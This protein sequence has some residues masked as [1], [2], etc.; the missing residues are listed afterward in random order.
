MGILLPQHPRG[1]KLWLEQ[2]VPHF[3]SSHNSAVSV[4]NHPPIREHNLATPPTLLSPHRSRDTHTH[5]NTTQNL[6]HTHT[7]SPCSCPSQARSASAQRNSFSNFPWLWKQYTCLNNVDISNALKH[8]SNGA[9]IGSKW[10]WDYQDKYGAPS[11]YCSL[12]TLL[13]PQTVLK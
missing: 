3:L 6:W 11:L 9:V 8:S 13:W 4:S 5:T 1:V 10:I 2:M 12:Q 7:H